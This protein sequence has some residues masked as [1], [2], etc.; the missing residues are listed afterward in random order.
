MNKHQQ[1]IQSQILT[2]IE[3]ASAEEYDRRLEKATEWF[4][5]DELDSLHAEMEARRQPKPLK[6]IGFC[7][8]IPVKEGDKVTLK[9]GA[10]FTTTKTTGVQVVKRTRTV[11]VFSTD[12]GCDP[13]KNYH[14]EQIPARNPR[15]IWVGGGGYWCDADINEIDF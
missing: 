12:K 11:T 6:Y 5:G 9:K 7:E 4:S 2:D 10:K 3:T 14:Q 13:Y 15:I 1:K 8:T